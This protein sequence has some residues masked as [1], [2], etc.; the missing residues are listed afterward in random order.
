MGRG[1][2]E[3]AV[4]YATASI[5]AASDPVTDAIVVVDRAPIQLRSKV[6][7]QLPH[8]V[9]GEV[10]EVT[11]LNGTLRCGDRSLAYL[12]FYIFLFEAKMLEVCD[13]ALT[14]ST[15]F[16]GFGDRRHNLSFVA[17]SQCHI[18]DSLRIEE[19][20]PSRRRTNDRTIL[21]KRPGGSAL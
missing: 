7:L 11:H 13:I 9:A 12:N 17:L 2:S 21:A 4:C 10:A 6:A 20:R 3:S 8:R 1:V 15:C 16:S 14:S 5:C 19:S 18:V